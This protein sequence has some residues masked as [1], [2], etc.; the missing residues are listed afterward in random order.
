MH[1]GARTAA[2]R[3][4]E[5]T[6]KSMEAFISAID[7]RFRHFKT[8]AAGLSKKKLGSKKPG[9]SGGGSGGG[10]KRKRDTDED[11]EAAE[12]PLSKS[13]FLKEKEK[14]KNAAK[15]PPGGRQ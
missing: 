15:R 11:E 4:A 1:V 7:K 10:G 12:S 5:K 2:D 3:Q 6:A 13:P 8:T 9:G 14:S